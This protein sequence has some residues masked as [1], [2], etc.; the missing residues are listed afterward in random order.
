M[1]GPQGPQTQAQHQKKFQEM[2]QR[3]NAMKS[4][5]STPPPGVKPKQEE[6]KH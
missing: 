6:H 3:L 2:Q 1:G 4:Q 5:M